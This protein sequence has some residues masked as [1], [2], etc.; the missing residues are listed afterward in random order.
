MMAD[1]EF[2]FDPV[3]PWAWLTS[4]WVEEVAQ[5]RDFT[6]DWKFISLSVLNEDKDYATDFAPGYVASHSSG[7]KLLRV[8]AAMVEDDPDTDVGA[9]YR[10]FAGDIHVRGRREEIFGDWEAGFPTY[11]ESVGVPERYLAAANREDRDTLIRASTAE[12]LERVGKD[13]GTPIVTFNEGQASSSFFGPVIS[14]VPRGEEALELWDA[15]WKLSLFP[16]FAELKRT[17]RERP[18]LATSLPE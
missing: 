7:L 4:R 13:V 1:I 8:L 9:W 6:V 12:G 5:L 14:R 3:C 10:Q 11:L 2:Y 16:G 18:Q 15:V 17:L